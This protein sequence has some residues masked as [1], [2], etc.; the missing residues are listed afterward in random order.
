MDCEEACA[1]DWLGAACALFWVI[2]VA[3]AA[4][5]LE[6]VNVLLA[7]AALTEVGDA[8]LLAEA[9]VWAEAVEGVLRAA[10]L[11]AADCAMDCAEAP[12]ML[13]LGSAL[14]WVV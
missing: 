13:W 8:S 3:V 7:P 9:A 11:L 12:L 5:G 1:M 2:T 6:G 4:C 10:V 14:G